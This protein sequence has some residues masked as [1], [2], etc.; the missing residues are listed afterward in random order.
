MY[1]T[2]VSA[3]LRRCSLIYARAAM[4]HVRSCREMMAVRGDAFLSRPD[5]SLRESESCEVAGFVSRAKITCGFVC[6]HHQL[7]RPHSWVHNA[8]R[9]RSGSQ[10]CA[11]V[12]LSTPRAKTIASDA[13]EASLQHL[14]PKLQ[15]PR[16]YRGEFCSTHVQEASWRVYSYSWSPPALTPLPHSTAQH[17]QSHD[18]LTT[19]PGS[20]PGAAA[21]RQSPTRP[22]SSVA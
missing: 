9:I 7:C 14:C 15:A 16:R 12:A 22:R 8:R 18:R 5:L 3:Q 6:P 21:K 10:G 17:Q 20:W 1:N 2:S 13:I 19:P 4:A 11:F